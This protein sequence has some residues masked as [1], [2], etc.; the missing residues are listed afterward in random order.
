VLFGRPADLP[1]DDAVGGEVLHELVG[2]PGEALAG[3][4][5][6]RRHVE[7]LQV[8]HERAGVGLVGEP[9][10]EGGSIRRRQV[11]TD[12]LGEL[13][14]RLGAQTAVEV[15]VQR[16]FGQRVDART[17]GQQEFLRARIH[18]HQSTGP[19]LPPG[20]TPANSGSVVA[21]ARISGP[22]RRRRR[23]LPEF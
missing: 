14:D 2:D 22:P 21:E 17:A 19:G 20:I 9:V 13:D 8:V 15:V 5:H 4:H 12:G 10:A 23:N 1:V 16:D 7:G 18:V 3:L 11:Q 6:G